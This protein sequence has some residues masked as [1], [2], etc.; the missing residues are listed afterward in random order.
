MIRVAGVAETEWATI[1]YHPTPFNT[2]TNDYKVTE[3]WRSVYGP[4]TEVKVDRVRDDAERA[5]FMGAL[6]T[7]IPITVIPDPAKI[8]SY[9]EPLATIHNRFWEAASA[10]CWAVYPLSGRAF[11]HNRKPH[12]QVHSL[13][14]DLY[15]RFADWKAYTPQTWVDQLNHWLE[16]VEQNRVRSESDLD[17][18]AG[19]LR[20][21]TR[22]LA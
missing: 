4:A 19:L 14:A 21:S 13:L 3:Y 11:R 10:V 12:D 2:R 6:R 16:L 8:E 17:A 1:T 5:N 18:L 20:S 15:W 22:G 7:D 9:V